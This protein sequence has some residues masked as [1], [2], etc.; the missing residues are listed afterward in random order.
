MQNVAAG[1]PDDSSI[2]PWVDDGPPPLG[3]EPELVGVQQA[4]DNAPQKAVQA[5]VQVKA[6][7]ETQS[8]S[9]DSMA[10]V[11][12]A[13]EWGEI[14]AALD[15]IPMVREFANNCF[16]EG[17]DDLVVHLSLSQRHETFRSEANEQ[18]LK[19]ALSEYYGEQVIL[20]F[21]IR[22][23]VQNT[24]AQQAIRRAEQAQLEAE[25]SIEN[26][27]VVHALKDTFGATVIPGSVKP[28]K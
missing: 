4:Q 1:L 26:D 15:V 12:E 21:S 16:L 6:A 24:P 8:S 22:S 2:P 11:E 20:K 7:A 10:P 23:E 25:A 5:S 14:V 27:R 9:G 13:G 17:R 19:S 18:R 3:S 28:L